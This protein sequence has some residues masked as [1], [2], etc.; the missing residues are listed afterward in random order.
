M[1]DEDMDSNSIVDKEARGVGKVI[2]HVATGFIRA[3]TAPVL[4]SKADLE[5][6][7]EDVSRLTGDDPLDDYFTRMLLEQIP[8][9]VERSKNL[10]ELVV[11]GLP[12]PRVTSYFKQATSCYIYGLYDAVAVLS[13]AVIEFSLEERFSQHGIPKP[14]VSHGKS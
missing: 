8:H 2:R 10:G 6:F 5:R 3:R 4:D 1:T 11:G 13:R 12:S 7:L 14:T 9:F